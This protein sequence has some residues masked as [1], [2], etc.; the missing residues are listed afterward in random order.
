MLAV[1]GRERR[2]LGLRTEGPALL[3]TDL[4]IMKPH[5]DT[6]EFEVVSLH[7]GVT[8]DDVRE[9]TGWTPRFAAAVG[10]TPPPDLVE[11]ETLRDLQARTARAHAARVAVPARGR[12]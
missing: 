9:R 7:P 11:L 5:P 10:D 12:A 2:A 1:E 4:C 8:R 3:V 6:K